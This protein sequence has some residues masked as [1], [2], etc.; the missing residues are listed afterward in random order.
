MRALPYWVS[1][2]LQQATADPHLRWRVPD[3]LG[4]SLVGSL[5]LSPGFWCTQGF[6]C[7]LQES[8]SPVLCEFCIQI[9]L[10]SK[11]KFPGGG[12]SVPL[13]DPQVGKSVVS[14]KTFLTVWEFLWYNVLQFVGHLLGSSLVGLTSTS[15]KRAYATGCMT[16]VAAPRVRAPAADWCWPV[17]PQETRTQGRLSLC[18]VSGSWCTQ[19]W[20]E[21]SKC[22]WQV[23]V[24][25]LNGISPLLPSC[26]GFSFALA[27]GVSFSGGIQ[28]PL[29]DGCSA[30][31]CNFGVLTG[32]DECTS[33]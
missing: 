27:D 16:Q 8:V 26:W 2:T 12:F 19:V 33:F 4:Q 11:V 32:E 23:W 6:I 10:A 22:L 24:L 20:F 30:E 18:G 7:A 1:P 21:P 25:I 17:P 15:S 9:P 29:V 14:P 31:S 3:T 5:L 13:P 28:H